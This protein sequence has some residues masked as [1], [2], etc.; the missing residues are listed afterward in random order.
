[1]PKALPLV[2]ACAETLDEIHAPSELLLYLESLPLSISPVAG[3]HPQM[4]E[5]GELH[6]SARCTVSSVLIPSQSITLAL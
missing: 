3:V 2:Q 1:M 6:I 5:A 4:I